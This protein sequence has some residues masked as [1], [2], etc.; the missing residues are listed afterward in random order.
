MGKFRVVAGR[1][2]GPFACL[3]AIAGGWLYLLAP[4]PVPQRLSSEV[5][6]PRAASTREATLSPALTDDRDWRA[7]LRA[8]IGRGY[9]WLAVDGGWQPDPE[10]R[11]DCGRVARVCRAIGAPAIIQFAPQQ[12]AMHGLTLHPGESGQRA[13]ATVLESVGGGDWSARAYGLCIGMGPGVGAPESL[14]EDTPVGPLLLVAPDAEAM[15]RMLACAFDVDIAVEPAVLSKRRDLVRAA[16]VVHDLW[17]LSV[18]EPAPALQ[19]TIPRAGRFEEILTG[20]ATY[21]GGEVDTSEGWTIRGWVDGQQL[22]A[23]AQGYVSRLAEPS[24][25]T[26]QR[27]VEAIAVLGDAARPALEA[28]LRSEERQ[29][30]VPAIQALGMIGSK[31]AAGPVMEVLAWQPVSA[32]VWEEAIRL[33]AIRTLGALKAASARALLLDLIRAGQWP[34]GVLEARVALGRV[35][36][37]AVPVSPAAGTLAE[38]AGA[39]AQSAR[40][41]DAPLG[42]PRARDELRAAAIVRGA[43]EAW[44]LTTFDILGGADDLWLVR[45]GP[46]DE[47]LEYVFTGARLGSGTGWMGDKASLQASLEGGDIRLRWKSYEIA[48]PARVPEQRSLSVRPAALRRD[49]DGDGL[50][51]VVERRLRT[52]PEAADTDGDGVPDGIDPSPRVSARGEVDEAGRV[53]QAL[54][55]TAWGG[56]SARQVR[57][58]A[59]YG[60]RAVPL[61]GYGGPA[62][63]LTPDELVAWRDEV[64][65]GAETILF[66]RETAAAGQWGP[67]VTFSPEGGDALC[68]FRA[69]RGPH[70]TRGYHARLTRSGK[71][72]VV[73][74]LARDW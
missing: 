16:S 13:L 5:S 63:W 68:T 31:R 42:R 33:Q 27:L 22:A 69:S 47:G 39:L 37:S 44:A 2:L 25:L 73:T 65:R 51:D 52:D 21:L 6:A 34:Q 24:A 14:A 12:P 49:S 17:P 23:A 30:L 56:D 11:D 67:G 57:A 9:T 36:P 58:I 70:D 43:G 72:W 53:V 7:K 45:L 20:L 71:H 8:P 74:E 38:P 35:D 46:S 1:A 32:S 55:A 66:G 28:A 54:W 60:A 41:S 64:G 15:V 10:D 62:I 50:A 59:A 19:C 4:S 61:Y 29:A 3:I 18:S 40:Y 26:D 48:Q